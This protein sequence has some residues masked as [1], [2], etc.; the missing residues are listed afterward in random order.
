M[1]DKKDSSN[2]PK[3]KQRLYEKFLKNRTHRNKSNY[4]IYKNLF[5]TIK[6][7]IKK[8]VLF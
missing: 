7:R 1:D 3:R 5:E 6:F 8:S 4:K 2:R